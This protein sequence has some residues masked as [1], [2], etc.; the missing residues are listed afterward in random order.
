MYELS[1][2]ELD[3]VAG[4]QGNGVGIGGLIGAGIGIGKIEVDPT[5]TAVNGNTVTLDNFLN[6]N[7]VQVPIGI[8]VALLGISAVRNF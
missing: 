6:N 3:M 7:N 1:D 2:R 8:A 4:G 5:I